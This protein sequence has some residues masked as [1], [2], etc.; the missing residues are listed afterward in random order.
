M[1]VHESDIGGTQSVGG[2]AAE[3]FEIEVV[4]KVDRVENNAVAC[5]CNDGEKGISSI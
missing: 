5:P 2:Q 1:R 4:L 3:G